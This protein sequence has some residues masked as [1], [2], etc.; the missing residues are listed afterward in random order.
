MSE[1]LLFD[2]HEAEAHIEGRVEEHGPAS[3]GLA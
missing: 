3:A 2:D 1:N